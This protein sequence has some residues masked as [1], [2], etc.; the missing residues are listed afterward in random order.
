MKE[1]KMIKLKPVKQ[2][3][4]YCGPACLKIVMDYYGVSKSERVWAKLTKA[5]RTKGCSES[6]MMKAAKKLGFKAYV[7]QRSSI[8]ELKRLNKKG[9]PVIVD[10]FSPEEAGHYAVVVGFQGNNILLA[11]S[12]FGKIKKHK[13][14][15]FEERWFDM[16]FKRLVTRE[17]IVIEKR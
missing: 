11:D 8:E 5:S 13:I 6:N 1:A 14:K 10:W 12:H 16:P 9:I 2:S 3:V 15:W 7:K 17:I 4:G